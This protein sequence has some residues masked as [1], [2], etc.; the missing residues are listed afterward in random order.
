M[1]NHLE[2]FSQNHSSMKSA[3][4][5]P[6]RPIYDLGFPK[7]TKGSYEIVCGGKKYTATIVDDFS[8]ES[9]GKCWQL[10]DGSTVQSEFVSEVTK[11]G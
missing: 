3:Q 5:R 8:L 4:E 11:I 1:N 2:S 6:A 7:A 10:P 9:P